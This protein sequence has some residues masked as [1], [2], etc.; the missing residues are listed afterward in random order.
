M[1][2]NYV[3]KQAIALQLGDLLASSCKYSPTTPAARGLI[4]PDW[5]A[6]KDFQ[7]KVADMA[8][9]HF[10]D[11]L[12]LDDVKK[13][14]DYCYRIGRS[15]GHVFSDNSWTGTWGVRLQ[16]LNNIMDILSIPDFELPKIGTVV[17]MYGIEVAI[18]KYEI[19]ES[20]LWVDYKPTNEETN[21][22]PVSI[23]WRELSLWRNKNEK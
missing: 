13:V 12:K 18:M 11:Y 17:E 9:L 10:Q 7:I 14:F 23:S 3:R 1:D 22:F 5:D 21:P 2:T 8:N 6:L 19:S 16:E 15:V 20:W 4:E